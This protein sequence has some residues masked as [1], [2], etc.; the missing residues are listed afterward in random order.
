M[1]TPVAPR[2]KNTMVPWSK[3][4]GPRMVALYASAGFAPV[5]G[6]GIIFTVTEL[7]R[8]ALRRAEISTDRTQ[9]APP[10]LPRAPYASRAAAVLGQRLTSEVAKS[11]L[12]P[13]ANAA[14]TMLG[15]VGSE[16]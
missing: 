1:R 13:A 9:R 6:G 2:L 12:V 16:T 7:G 3:W 4:D 8:P 15:V 5:G 11:R 14:V 10:L